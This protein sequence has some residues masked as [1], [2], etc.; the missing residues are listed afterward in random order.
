MKLSSV[1]STTSLLL[2]TALLAEISGV[3]GSSGHHQHVA[4]HQ[5]RAI[6]HR[7]ERRALALNNAPRT[8]RKRRSCSRAAAAAASKPPTETS[9]ED[10][11]SGPVNVDIG[12]KP[13]NWPTKTQP[14][15]A[16]VSHR[17]TAPDPYLTELSKSYNNK[18]NKF[19]NQ[20]HK[21]DM[22]F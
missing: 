4:R 14:G 6:T 13:A 3:Q 8:L 10:S 12:I 7:M 21:G 9:K 22:T 15:A 2:L 17:T 5:Q 1:F 18:D 16:P 11:E 19:Y 20:V